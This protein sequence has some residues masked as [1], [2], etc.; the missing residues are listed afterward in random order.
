MKHYS[1]KQQWEDSVVYKHFWVTDEV[2]VSTLVF[3]HYNNDD[4]VNISGVYVHED[5]R[6]KGIATMMFE[7]LDKDTPHCLEVR[8]DNLQA[9]KLYEKLGFHYWQESDNN[10]IWMKDFKYSKK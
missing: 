3:T 1:I 8:R 6:Q 5:Y 2:L 7:T 4:A 10:M 9:I